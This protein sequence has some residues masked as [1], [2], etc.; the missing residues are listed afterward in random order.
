MAEKK[1][2][3]AILGIQRSATEDDIKSAYRRK[4]KK[5]HPDLNPGD[6]EAE[7]HF[8]QI[9]EAYAVLSD[10]EKRSVYD[11]YGSDG[12]DAQGFDP[13]SFNINFDDIL[14]SFFGGFGGFGR[15]VSPNAPQRGSDLRYRM[16]L[17]FMDAAFGTSRDISVTKDDYC[18]S[19][20]GTGAAPGTRVETCP[21]CK[22]SGQIH[23]T[24]Q[25]MIGQMMTSQPCYTCH[26]TGK[27]IDHPC[28]TC[29][30]AGKYRQTKTL[31]VKIP[32]GIDHGEMLT[33]RGEGEA[34]E[35][36]GPPGDLYIEIILQPH[37]IFKRRGSDTFC[38]LPIT[39]AQAALGADVEVPTIDG[40]VTYS[41][42]EGSQ[43]GDQIKLRGK[44]IPKINRSGQRGD[45][46][47]TLRIEVPR[48]LNEKQKQLLRDFDNSCGDPNYKERVS[49]FERIKNFI[50]NR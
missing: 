21:T 11:R 37:Q 42:P 36:G 10:P 50:T 31:T 6:K 1:D 22:G 5:Y 14:G 40:T 7:A 33:L 34:G 44:G 48:R 12:L 23:E 13:T 30:G 17:D 45:H 29:R 20:E 49:F 19:C 47:C 24:R 8:K 46:I 4:A 26:G 9:N 28:S 43:N 3:Y 15:A 32:A 16:R 18:D 35:N 27:K 39:F 25:T 41:I 38:E 2:Y